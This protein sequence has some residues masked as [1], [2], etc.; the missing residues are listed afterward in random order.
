MQICVFCST[1]KL[2][3]P[4]SISRYSTRLGKDVENDGSPRF[5]DIEFRRGRIAKNEVPGGSKIPLTMC[6][7]VPENLR[8]AEVG[9]WKSL[10]F[11]W[12]FMVFSPL[13]FEKTLLPNASKTATRHGRPE[14]LPKTAKFT[15]SL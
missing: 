12:F 10:K 15:K 11:H 9:F 14:R 1:C 6:F 4:F 13:G 2:K 7:V 3:R 5:I 8:A